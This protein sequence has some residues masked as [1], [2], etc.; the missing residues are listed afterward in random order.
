MLK[1]L[2]KYILKLVVIFIL[3]FSAQNVNAQYKWVEILCEGL[4]LSTEFAQSKAVKNT[5]L[6]ALEN[7]T[8]ATKKALA[9]MDLPSKQVDN[10][11]EQYNK[12]EL[13]VLLKQSDNLS[14]RAIRVMLSDLSTI[15]KSNSKAFKNFMEASKKNRLV[16]E[17]VSKNLGPSYRTDMS[18]LEQINKGT[19]PVKLKTIN[20]DLIG[21]ELENVNYVKKKVSIDGIIYEGVFLKVDKQSTL[22]TVRLPKNMIGVGND[23]QFVESTKLVKKQYLKNP[24]AL[25]KQLVSS[26]SRI[27]KHDKEI[28]NKNKK[29][30]LELQD[31][32]NLG[33]KNIDKALV[34]ESLKELRKITKEITFIRTSKEKPFEMFE[35]DEIIQAQIKDIQNPKASTKG[36]I[37]GFVWHH[38]EKK[39]SME[40]VEKYAHDVNKHTGGNSIWNQGIR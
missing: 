28:F 8:T 23:L 37:F 24:E 32:I 27:L 15:K 11:L 19:T 10:L 12:A 30:I 16:Y 33:M 34:E 40:L 17:R 14:P 18:V 22:S 4:D 5:L 36:R 3:F 2:N 21:K 35:M 29:V 38:S 20:E 7:S 1:T 25:K 39:G 9:K 31:K 6:S 13:I 26:N